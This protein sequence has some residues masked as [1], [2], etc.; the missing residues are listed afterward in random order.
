MKV[1]K[2]DLIDLEEQVVKMLDFDLRDV[3]CI[4]F[5]DR[6]LRLFGIDEQ[7]KDKTT[8]QIS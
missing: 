7:N 5:L 3:A 8:K 6:F 2:Q 1:N 4:H